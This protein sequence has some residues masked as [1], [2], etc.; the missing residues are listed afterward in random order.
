VPRPTRASQ[1]A[2]AAATQA[3]D[4]TPHLRVD[5]PLVLIPTHVATRLGTSVTDL[6]KRSFRVQDENKD[7]EITFFAWQEAPVSVGLVFDMSASMKSKMATA[8]GAVAEFLQTPNGD[9]EFFLVEFNEKPRLAVPFTGDT[10]R[11]TQRI[12]R[13][14]PYGR[15]CLYDGISLALRQMKSAQNA[16]KVILVISDGG[17]NRS[18]QTFREVRNAVLESDAQIYSIGIFEEPDPRYKLPPEELRG[19]EVLTELAESS[20]GRH[21]TVESIDDLA[22]VCARIGKELR[23]QYVLGYTP[24]N[25]SRD[26][27]Y[28]RVRVS[29]PAGGQ[30]L[31]VRHRR[32]Y[33]APVN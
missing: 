29:V 8:R 17:D 20:G 32:G 22:E 18:R 4:D 5:S 21:F 3:D 12:A 11:L 14:W 9:D 30:E 1:A 19:E 25:F 15:T 10:K 23:S 28:H 27:K 13:A 24:N 2:A 26:G 6:D 7:Q 33:P 31:V 16:R